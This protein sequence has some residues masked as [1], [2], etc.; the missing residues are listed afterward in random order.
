MICTNCGAEIKPGARFCGQCGSSIIY[1]EVDGSSKAKHESTFSD[2]ENNYQHQSKQSDSQ[3][4]GESKGYNFIKAYVIFVK[5]AFNF[6][7]RTSCKYYWM[8]IF[9]NIVITFL[10]MLIIGFLTADVAVQFGFLWVVYLIFQFF[11]TIS[12]FCRRIRDAGVNIII[13]TLLLLATIIPI[14]RYFAGIGLII[15]LSQPSKRAK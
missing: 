3:L 10:F 4:V 13:V 6:F 14:I 1:R 5:Q 12:L 15:C 7:G 8:A 11:A 9:M 2:I